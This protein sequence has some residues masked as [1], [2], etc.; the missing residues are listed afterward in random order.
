MMGQQDNGQGM[1]GAGMM[2]SGMGMMSTYAPSSRPISQDEARRRA[3]GFAARYGLGVKIRDFMVFTQNYYVQIVDAR[4]GAGLGELLVDRYTGV[5]QPEFGPNM[6]WNTRFGMGGNAGMMGGTMMGTNQIQGMTGGQQPQGG[7]GNQQSQ[8]MMGN[9]ANQGIQGTP[10]ARYTLT[11]A[12]KVA[13]SFVAGYLPGG[14][15]LEGIAFPGYYT[16]NYGSKT[17]EGMLSVNASTGEVWVHGWHG[18]FLGA[19]K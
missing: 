6:M 7:M 3:S 12:Q 15:V 1:M 19:V 8:G 14:K 4:T 18:Q 2:G 10:A 5:V 17:T 11:S 9:R 13:D 16:F